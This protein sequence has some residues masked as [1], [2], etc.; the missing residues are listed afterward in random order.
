MS[1]IRGRK[2]NKATRARQASKAHRAIRAT[3]ATRARQASKAHR[4]IKATPETRDLKASKAHRA[5]KAMS[6]TRDLKASKA[7]RARKGNK[8][9]RATRAAPVSRVRQAG[10]AHR[11]IRATPETRDHKAN[12]AHKAIRA[13]PETRDHKANKAHRAIRATP[14]TRDLKAS[15]AHRAIRAMPETRA[16]QASRVLRAIRAMSA[17]RDRKVN[18]AFRAKRATPE[19]RDRKVNRAFRAKKATSATRDR[20]AS[21]V[22]RAKRAT[23]ETRDLKGRR[24]DKGDT[25]SYIIGDGLLLSTG[26]VL[27]VSVDNTLT[28]N[29]GTLGVA[30]EGVTAD[31]LSNN[32][33]QTL[34]LNS[35][36]IKSTA[37]VTG[38]DGVVLVDTTSGQV[39]LTLPS[40]AGLEGRMFSFILVQGGFPLAVQPSGVETIDGAGTYTLSEP[41]QAATLISDGTNWFSLSHNFIF[42]LE[43][44]AVT[45]GKLADVTDN[46]TSGQVL[47]SNGSGGFAWADE[48][49]TTY[50]A[51]ESTLTLSGGEFSIKD[52]G[53]TATRLGAEAV[54]EEKI[55]DGAVSGVKLVSGAVTAVKLSGAGGHG[56][57]G[58][59]LA[60]SGG[61]GFAWADEEN[62]TYTADESTLTLSAGEFSVKDSG[63]TATQLG[64]EAVT[65]EKIKD[66]AVSGGKLGSGAVTAVKLSGT[67]GNGASGQ[68][69]TSSGGGGFAWADEGNTTY[70]ADESTLTLSAGE[71]SVKD[72]GVTAT[73]LVSGAV[74]AAK[75]SGAGGHGTSG[76]VLT[77]NGAG[78]FAWDDDDDTTYTADESTLTLSGGKFSVK[79]LGVTSTQLVS[80]AVTAVKLSGAGGNGT[81][82]QV[83]TSSGSGGFAWSDDDNTTYTADESTLALSGGKFSVMD[84]GVTA[85]QLISGAVTA[86]KLSGAGGNGTSGQVLTSNGIGGFA[87]DDDDDTTYTADESTLTLSGG[88]FSVKDSG[89]TGTQLGSGAVT[90]V[91]LSG[92]GGNGTSGQVL[93]FSGSGGFAWADEENTT[94]T[95]DESTLTLSGDEFSIKDSGVTAT[96]LGSGAVTAVKLSGAGGNG[97]SGQVLTSDGTGGFAWAGDDDTT[98][99]ADEI[100]LTLSGGEFSVK[101]SGVTGTQ[102]GSGAVTAVKLSGAGGNGTSGQVLTSNGTGGFAWADEEDTTYTADG[103][104]LTL[105]GGEFSVKDSGVTGTQLG[106]GAVTAVKLSG[107]GGN[108]TSGQVLTS[109]GSGGFAWAGDDDTT[110]TADE[111]TLTL[112]GGEFS[113]KDSGVTGTQL[114]SGA[115]TAVKLSGA[116]GNGTSGQVLTSNGTGGFAWAGDDDTTYTADESTLTLSSGEF[117]VKDSGVTAAKLGAGSVTAGKIGSGAVN[118]TTVGLNAGGQL[119]VIDGSVNAGTLDGHDSAYFAL[120]SHTHPYWSLTGNSGTDPATDFLGASDRIS[121]V[122]GVTGAPALRIL[123]VPSGAAYDIPNILGGY[124]GNTLLYPDESGGVFIGGGGFLDNENTA[125]SFSAVVGGMGNSA[126]A[127]SFAGGGNTNNADSSSC[128][129]GGGQYNTASAS[130]TF[131][132]GGQYNAASYHF[133]AIGGGQHNTVDTSMNIVIGGGQ[134]NTAT[135]YY[136]FIGGGRSNTA[137][138]S[139]SIAGGYRAKANG[140]GDFV[141]ADSTN[142]DFNVNADKRFA[143]RAAGG[144]YLYTTGDLTKFV[145]LDGDTNSWMSDSDRNLKENIVEVDGYGVLEKLLT[146]PISTWNFKTAGNDLPHMGPMAQDFYA[147][148]GLGDDDTHISSMDGMGVSLAA[149]LGLYLDMKEKNGELESLIEKQTEEIKCLE[150][151]LVALYDRLTP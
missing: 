69:L 32:A 120:A 39:D 15:K 150:K 16:R 84:S 143:V 127:T 26:G 46:G 93:T 37:G 99:T 121:L 19:T 41:N 67:G 87:W 44:G 151:R 141:W 35:S 146:V 4:A 114:G 135:G 88:E 102:L 55:K 83:L 60:S 62:T 149:I 70:T 43:D 139:L 126:K 1:A 94:Y 30:D 17:T 48:E 134:Y 147:A 2:G 108:G 91:K 47:T 78:G 52:S 112:S 109:N 73:Q 115:V 85:T 98:Y 21:R 24:A 63:V 56:A 119:E 81:S 57:S 118:G 142:N 49:N 61:G 131:I 79:D 76:Q 7:H 128:I 95:A 5:I 8:A 28:F 145:Y 34:H 25:G 23:P 14:E 82:G 77:S 59:V 65:E 74:T 117:S 130:N 138:G 45:A 42:V 92:A 148:Y 10:K 144:V 107:A 90:A 54:T 29:A 140:G 96:Q 137:T 133:G 125:G 116:G 100:T 36:L 110:Y 80:G 22:P 89:V 68:V 50:T 27:G 106:S 18:R 104:T 101:D 31:K 124:S 122:L 6:E 136:T 40:A 53:V 123:P 33:K 13:T 66:G 20:K 51:D 3:P 129:V 105:S 9:L 11:A 86:V 132:G 97:T 38:N 64:I 103:S 113:V 58:Q 72:S 71:F 111:S 12:K 75:L